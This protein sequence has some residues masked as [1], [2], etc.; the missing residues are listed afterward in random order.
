MQIWPRIVVISIQLEPCVASVKLCLWLRFDEFYVSDEDP[1]HQGGVLLKAV[2]AK[3][4][5]GRAKGAKRVL[6]SYLRE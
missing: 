6:Q 2:P 4:A 5:T 1:R 3:G